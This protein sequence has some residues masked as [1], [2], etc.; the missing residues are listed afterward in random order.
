MENNIQAKN[1]VWKKNNEKE[2]CTELAN[3]LLSFVSEKKNIKNRKYEQILGSSLRAENAV[4][5]EFD[6]DTICSYCA[7]NGHLRPGEKKK[8][9]LDCGGYWKSEEVGR[10][11]GTQ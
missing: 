8:K 10:T 9:R 5:H 2:M 7:L 11:T 4:E 3:L 1:T 6:D